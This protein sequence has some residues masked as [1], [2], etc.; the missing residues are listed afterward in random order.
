MLSEEKKE[1]ISYEVIRTLYSK[2]RDFPEDA[3]KNRNAPFHKAF[4][5]A[6][7]DKL[8]GKVSD[9]P[10]F[11]SLSSWSHGLNTSLGQSFFEKVSHIL[12]DG[13]KKEFRS[14]RISQAQQTTISDIITDLKNGNELPNLKRENELIYKN[15][16]PTNK[17]VSNFT[18]DC[19]F[20]EDDKIVAIELKTVKPNSGIFKNEK[21]KI[22][23]AKAGLKND[24]K[25]K[26]I[27]YYLGFPF[28]P[29]SEDPC[30]FDKEKYMNYSI[31]C[32]KYFEQGEVLLASEL[33]DFLSGDIKTMEQ[34]IEIIN[35][36]A[37]TEFIENYEF[38]NNNSKKD[39][40]KEEYCKLLEKWNLISELK[41]V[42]N[43]L[44][45]KKSI[46]ENKRL[47]RRYNQSIFKD[48]KYNKD[49]FLTLN[50][51]L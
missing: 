44:S 7:K 17:S 25:E 16:K 28:D 46:R 42:N 15:N 18:I 45:I 29:L 6:F 43:E 24:L 50:Q 36:I 30:G 13:T 32:T 40:K 33:W 38:L 48:G 1:N 39:D 47:I 21:E 14:L 12:S 2:F 49:R 11:I 20:E 26:E 34:I 9:I 10:I 35:A 41:L 8:E 19:Y 23:S 22:L 31:D 4:L 51:L 5:E 37:T 3:A 27:H